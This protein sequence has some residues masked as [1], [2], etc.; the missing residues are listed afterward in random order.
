MI[1]VHDSG[2]GTTT[3]VQ[4]KPEGDL[5]NREPEQHHP[6]DLCTAAHTLLVTLVVWCSADTTM[7]GIIVCH[8]DPL[9][10][11]ST[12]FVLRRTSTCNNCQRDGAAPPGT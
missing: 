1:K 12:W 11:Y 3:C 10:S 2:H 8:G 7:L 4:H 9:L 5:G 6:L